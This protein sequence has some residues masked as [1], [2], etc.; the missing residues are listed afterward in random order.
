MRVMEEGRA[1][2]PIAIAVLPVAGFDERGAVF[3]GDQWMNVYRPA[4]TRR[5]SEEN[6]ATKNEESCDADDNADYGP[7]REMVTAATR[8][9]GGS[10]DWRKA[11]ENDGDMKGGTG[12]RR[13][14]GR[15]RRR[16]RCGGG[17]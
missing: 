6:E 16:E 11:G 13:G 14:A 2:I 1:R 12:W 10:T 8:R 5:A 9:V 3:G 7:E 15:S 17:G 4:A